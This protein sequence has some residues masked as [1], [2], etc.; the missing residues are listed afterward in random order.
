MGPIESVFAKGK[1]ALAK[2]EAE[3]TALVILKFRSGG[4]GLIEA[5]T[6]TRPR[7][8]EASIS[9][10]GSKGT[11][12]IGGFAVNK[13]ETWNVP[14]DSLTFLDK[15]NENPKD[16]YGF[17]H[18]KFYR[19]IVKEIESSETSIVDGYE[20]IKTVKIINAIYDSI[21]NGVEIFL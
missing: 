14:D 2:I 1:T 9:L 7:D 20:G 8:L 4:L 19:Q 18:I 13:I 12:V 17:G 15:L 10:L 11:V 16:V 3:D 6:A 5:T 21:K